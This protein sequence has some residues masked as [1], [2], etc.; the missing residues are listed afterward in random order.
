MDNILSKEVDDTGLLQEGLV[1]ICIIGTYIKRQSNLLILKEDKSIFSAKEL[2]YCLRES[3]EA[4]SQG[5]ITASLKATCKGSIKAVNAV[6]IYDLY[7][8]IIETILPSLEALFIN[9]NISKGLVKLKL[10]IDADREEQ[11][12]GKL[13]KKKNL[14][15]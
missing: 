14:R 6:L 12:L 9:L 4:I 7:E 15:V 10:Q 8:D 5:K 13:N 2:E 1:E 3:M 11:A